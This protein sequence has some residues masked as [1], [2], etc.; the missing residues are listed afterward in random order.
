MILYVPLCLVFLITT[1]LCECDYVDSQKAKATLE[2]EF[3][4]VVASYSYQLPESCPLDVRKDMLAEFERRKVQMSVN[5]WKCEF[6]KCG[7]VF[8]SEHF[9]HAHFMRKHA[10]ALPSEGQC[11]AKL[12]PMLSFWSDEPI[13]ISNYNPDGAMKI[14]TRFKRLHSFCEN[15]LAKCF[16][17]EAGVESHKLQEYFSKNY[18]SMISQNPPKRLPKSRGRLLW[19]VITVLICLGIIGFYA[20]I[21]SIHGLPNSR[22][23]MNN[24]LN[25]VIKKHARKME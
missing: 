16:P 2:E 20:A 14:E 24:A 18:C 25:Q 17:P 8:L 4:P 15:I 19:I 5:R 11:L 12:W 23:T 1:V 22:L 3:N 13:D 21:S 6:Y 10:D 7:K 9:L